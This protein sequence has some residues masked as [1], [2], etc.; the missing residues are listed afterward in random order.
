MADEVEHRQH[1]L[2][3]AAPETPT[4]L[5]QEHGRALRGTQHEQNIDRGHVDALVEQVDREQDLDLA[6]RQ[7]VEGVVPFGRAAVGRDGAG[8]DAGPVEAV[9]EEL[10]VGDAHAEAEGPHAL[11]VAHLLPHRADHLADPEVVGRVDVGQLGRV[12]AATPPPT[13]VSQVGA[14]V[15][16][17]VVERRQQVL[18]ERVPQAQLDGDA[19]AEPA[20]DVEPVGPLRRRRQAQQVHRAHVVE[21]RRVGGRSGV[22]ELVDDHHVEVLGIERPQVARRQRLDRG[23]DVLPAPVAE[24]RPPTARRSCR[25]ED[26]PERRPLTR[27]RISLRWAT[28][29]S[30]ARSR[31]SRSRR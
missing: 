10:A 3:G 27:S 18:F 15:D 9:G 23:E 12:V 17:V 14:V 11:R 7:G 2:A 28:N 25:P 31:R 1:V 29:S 19:A 13:D 4:Q 16:P 24:H 21:Q 5:L 30:R 6:R 22:V 8:G 20:Q 26:V